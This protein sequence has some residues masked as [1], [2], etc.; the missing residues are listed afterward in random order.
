MARRN[1]IGGLAAIYTSMVLCLGPAGLRFV[2]EV[3]RV[4]LLPAVFGLL[5]L[6]IGLQAVRPRPE[7]VDDPEDHGLFVGMQDL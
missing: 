7:A 1:Q 4:L 6:V 5:A 2:G 3:P